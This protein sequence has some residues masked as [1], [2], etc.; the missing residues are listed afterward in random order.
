MTKSESRK[1]IMAG[2][3]K[4]NNSEIELILMPDDDSFIPMFWACNR[5][6]SPL[7]NFIS[8][9]HAIYLWG[10][11]NAHNARYSLLFVCYLLNH[12][13]RLVCCD[14]EEKQLSVTWIDNAFITKPN[15]RRFMKF[16]LD[17][18]EEYVKIKELLDE[19]KKKLLPHETLHSYLDE[20]PMSLYKELPDD[21][22]CVY[23]VGQRGYQ[24]SNSIHHNMILLEII[25]RPECWK[26]FTPD[27]YISTPVKVGLMRE[28]IYYIDLKNR[29]A[30]MG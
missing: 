20:I 12:L 17:N 24:C 16:I 7:L 23:Q 27:V 28:Y 3:D 25:H 4:V 19:K 9:N 21:K 5:K 30:T 11:C 13:L 18:L 14:P 1:V 26:S 15:P 22:C 8:C 2:I 10:F 6:L 29:I